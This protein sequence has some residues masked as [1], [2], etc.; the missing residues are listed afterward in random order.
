M[1][2]ELIK[3]EVIPQILAGALAA[4]GPMGTNE[5]AW[6][7]KLGEAI[8][9]IASMFNSGSRQW[10]I[11]EQVLEAAV[12]VV[13][14]VSHEVETNS[15]RALVQLDSGRPSKNYPDGIEPIRTH[16]TDTAAG[17]AMLARLEK[18]EP[19]QEIIVWKAMESMGDGV[20]ANKVRVLVHME[21]RPV[22]KD[23][24]AQVSRIPEPPRRESEGAVHGSAPSTPPADDVAGLDFAHEQF[25]GLNG[26]GKAA[27][28][29]I[30]RE[31]GIKF[32]LPEAAQV[33]A[34]LKVIGEV[35][36]T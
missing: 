27:C 13:T 33:N 21:T 19:G 22:F 4:A 31:Q 10:K 29:R 16:R 14:Y 24:A 7:A 2:E 18:L 20:D 5:A 17:K 3:S 34:F 28:V 1:S 32:P 35:T 8:P 11:T 36:G 9:H 12:F 26:K 23:R 15:T 6:K 30:F 25:D